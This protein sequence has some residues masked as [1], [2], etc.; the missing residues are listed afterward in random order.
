M[1]LLIIQDRGVHESQRTETDFDHNGV[2]TLTDADTGSHRISYSG[3]DANWGGINPHNFTDCEAVSR[4]DDYA[5]IS[6][7]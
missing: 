1:L 7:Y 4:S 6:L 2:I 3:F 5:N